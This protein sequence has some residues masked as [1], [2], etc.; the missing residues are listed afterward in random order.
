[1]GTVA[2]IHLRPTTELPQVFAE[3]IISIIYAQTLHLELLED[4]YC[5]RVS[6]K[7]ELCSQSAKN[8]SDSHISLLHQVEL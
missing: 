4:D 5:C 2:N 6:L 8:T 7:V 1:M 3:F